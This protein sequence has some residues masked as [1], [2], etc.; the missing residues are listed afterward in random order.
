MV[1]GPYREQDIAVYVRGVEET[2][3]GFKSLQTPVTNHAYSTHTSKPLKATHGRV[4]RN[5]SAADKIS[6]TCDITWTHRDN[7]TLFGV[8]IV[9]S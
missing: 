7:V 9:T 5:L 6:V 4:S 2:F 3:A 1:K 8:V